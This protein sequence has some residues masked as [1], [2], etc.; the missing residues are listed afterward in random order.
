MY[1]V[2]SNNTVTRILSCAEQD[3]PDNSIEYPDEAQIH[4]GCD[5]RFFSSSGAR[6]TVAEAAAANLISVGDNQ[7]ALWENGKYVVKDDYTN[8]PAW[9]KS[10]GNLRKLALG[11][12]LDSTLTL[13]MPPDSEAVWQSNRWVIPSAVKERRAREK[14]DE[15]LLKSD[16]VMLPDY[17]STNKT[18]WKTYRQALRDVPQQATFPSNITWPTPPAK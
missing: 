9:E 15:L 12:S 13:K 3:K 5:V 11:E 18:A 8:T 4:V 2:T 1:A 6:L 16:C 17:P 7:R 10:T 14:R